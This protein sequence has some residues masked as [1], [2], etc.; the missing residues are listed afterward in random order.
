MTQ[1]FY[2]KKDGRGISPVIS[3]VILSAMVLVIGVSVWS[4]ATS[5][6]SVISSGYFEEVM[7]SVENVKERFCVENVGFDE[8]AQ[9]LKIWIFNYGAIAITIEAISVKGG[10]NVYT[11]PGGGEVSAGEF[12]RVDVVPDNI[13]LLSG[14]SVTVEVR[15]N[16]GNKAYDSIL[17]P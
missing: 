6:S 12:I 17:L 14:L 9:M 4:V 11:H 13:S 10:G 2:R 1:F 16:R 5:A 3:S 15:S 8:D 7:V